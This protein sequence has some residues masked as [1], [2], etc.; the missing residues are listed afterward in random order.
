MAQVTKL[1][2]CTWRAIE[3]VNQLVVCEEETGESRVE[4]IEH[5]KKHIEERARQA[6]GSIAIED[7]L[8]SF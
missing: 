3:A 7:L 5:V 4:A 6:G 1:Q 8:G 2:D